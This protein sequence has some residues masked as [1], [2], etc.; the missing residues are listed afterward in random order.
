MPDLSGG[1]DVQP[2]RSGPR[3]TAAS[4]PTSSCGSAL[5]S[6]VTPL[7]PLSCLTDEQLADR[8]PA[9]PWAGGILAVNADHAVAHRGY[10]EGGH[11]S[12]HP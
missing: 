1:D 7:Q 5:R 6:G 2:R 9:A 11:G 3:S 8:I 10:G 12:E 4:R